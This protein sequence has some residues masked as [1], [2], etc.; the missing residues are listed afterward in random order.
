[1][2]R[3]LRVMYNSD[4]LSFNRGA[5][6]PSTVPYHFPVAHL[7]WRSTSQ[8]LHT[9]G[10]HRVAPDGLVRVCEWVHDIRLPGSHRHQ[11]RGVAC[12]SPRTS[13]I[14]RVFVV[15]P[16]PNGNR[17]ELLGVSCGQRLS[18]IHRGGGGNWRGGRGTRVGWQF[19]GI[20]GA[21]T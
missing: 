12:I 6:D 5:F 17:A 13:G 11:D 21:N 9:P 7:V 4:H 3:T 20:K 16:L 18:M 14:P 15:D 1:M 8:G 19:R 10:P 2:S